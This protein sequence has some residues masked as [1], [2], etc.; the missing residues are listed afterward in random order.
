M[1]FRRGQV[2]E[3]NTI[4]GVAFAK[5]KIA[6]GTTIDGVLVTYPHNTSSKPFIEAD[7][8]TNQILISKAPNGQLYGKLYNVPLQNT[9]LVA[10][11]YQAGNARAGSKIFFNKDGNITITTPA[12]NSITIKEGGDIEILNTSGD[13]NVLG[14][15]TV[16]INGQT[17]ELG[18]NTAA[19]LNLLATMTVD[20][21][22]SNAAQPV[23]VVASGQT[24]DK[25]KA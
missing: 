11:E 12:G 10:G 8:D 20:T 19:V 16:S 17:V 6:G 15:N 2:L 7:S 13:I 5:V 14:S 3:I 21:T 23:I 25:V 18:N 22:T 24:T 1:F 4:N 9:D